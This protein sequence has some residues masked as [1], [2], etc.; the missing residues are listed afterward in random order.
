VEEIVFE[1]VAGLCAFCILLLSCSVVAVEITGAA[2][3]SCCE[4][5]ESSFH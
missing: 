5:Y 3:E 4:V 1:R 2:V